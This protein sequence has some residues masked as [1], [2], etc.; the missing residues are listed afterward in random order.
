MGL[1][2]QHS[3]EYDAYIGSPEWEVRRAAAMKKANNIC[4]RCGVS[5]EPKELDVH[6]LTYDRLGHE[7]PSDLKVV[8][9]RCHPAEDEE[10]GFVRWAVKKYGPRGKE[11]IN[12]PHAWRE[13]RGDLRSNEKREA[14]ELR[15]RERGQAEFQASEMHDPE[16]ERRMLAFCLIDSSTDDE[17]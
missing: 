1:Y 16:W 3:P 13:Y 11:Q 10:R 14:E 17:L 6:H 15:N 9:R 7:W 8:C 5:F 4:E 2:A 12:D